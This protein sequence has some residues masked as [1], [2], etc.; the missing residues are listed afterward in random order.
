MR[1]RLRRRWKSA[2]ASPESRNTASCNVI[3]THGN[4]AVQRS[5]TPRS[6]RQ[7]PGAVWVARSEPGWQDN[8]EAAEVVAEIY[9]CQ[10]T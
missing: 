6:C 3:V 10:S 2:A 4:G 8:N 5:S 7:V 9:R 1:I